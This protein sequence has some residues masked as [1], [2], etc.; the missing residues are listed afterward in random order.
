MKAVGENMQLCL[1]LLRNSFNIKLQCTARINKY[2]SSYVQGGK[3]QGVLHY[4]VRQG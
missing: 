4:G 1:S 3:G 2:G